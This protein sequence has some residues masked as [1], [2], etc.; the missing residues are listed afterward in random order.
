MQSAVAFNEEKVLENAFA[1]DV[2]SKRVT[3]E[4]VQPS[5]KSEN[6]PHDALPQA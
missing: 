4:Q 1:C 3:F 5:M 6:K 2:N